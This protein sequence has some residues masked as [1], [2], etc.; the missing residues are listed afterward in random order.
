MDRAEARDALIRF[1]TCLDASG[2]E[3]RYF[4]T[5]GT[6]LGLVR[7]GGF[8]ESD[9]DIDFG[10]WAEDY[11]PELADALVAA[12]FESRG[13]L[14]KP[15]N[16]FVQKF[17]RGTIP[18]DLTLYYRDGGTAWSAI[19]KRPH[20]QIRSIYSAFGTEP[21][22]FCGVPVRVPSPPESYLRAVYGA[23]WRHPVRKWEY[24]YA[25]ENLHAHGSWVWKLRFWY[26]RT[27]WRLRNRNNHIVDDETT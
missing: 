13:T 8:I 22:T 14:G 4:V 19:Y 3:G 1:V 17:A 11:D 23:K 26:G 2:F 24:R 10:M 25:P 20:E 5:D 7:E 21:A 15:E 12:G 6:L 18:I 27:I 16:G 9:Y